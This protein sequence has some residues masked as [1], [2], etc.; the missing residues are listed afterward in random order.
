[1]EGA[2]PPNLGGQN[3]GAKQPGPSGRQR[4]KAQ[5]PSPSDLP[6]SGASWLAG[7]LRH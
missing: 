4:Q 5:D 2:G 1:M 7:L 3:C 6:K